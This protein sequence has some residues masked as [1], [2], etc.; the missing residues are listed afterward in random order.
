VEKTMVDSLV[1]K[2]IACHECD[3]FHTYESIPVGAKASFQICGLIMN[4]WK[5]T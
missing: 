3:H 5:K 1:G 2:I 4:A